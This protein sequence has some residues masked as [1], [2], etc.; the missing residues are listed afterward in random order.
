MFLRKASARTMDPGKPKD[1]LR[2]CKEHVQRKPKESYGNL[3]NPKENLW[4]PKKPQG[5]IRNRKEHLR[6]PKET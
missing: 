4:K 1:N 5:N 2:N 6:K 3:Q